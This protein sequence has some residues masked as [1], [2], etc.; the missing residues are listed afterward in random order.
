MTKRSMYLLRVLYPTSLEIDDVRGK[1]NI[2]IVTSISNKMTALEVL[3]QQVKLVTT[4][5]TEICVAHCLKGLNE[6]N[7]KDY[8]FAVQ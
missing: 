3:T 2:Y 6:C 7:T 4:G 5:I 1:K 8:P